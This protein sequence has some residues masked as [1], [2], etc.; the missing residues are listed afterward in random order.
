M[1]IR[2][3]VVDDSSFMRHRLTEIFSADRDME[4]VG[5]ASNGLEAVRKTL[6]LCPDVI[7]MD[8]EM[9]VMDGITSVR[10]IMQEQPTP[11]LMFSVCTKAG[12]KATFESLEAGAMD[13][14][15][16]QLY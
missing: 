1:T 11:I 7:T 16:K 2:I 12:A 4:V 13:F 8:V 10:H 15:P 9:P 3:L 14:M 6:A 5:V